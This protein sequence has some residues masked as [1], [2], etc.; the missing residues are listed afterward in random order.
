MVQPVL[1][2]GWTVT[3]TLENVPN[4]NYGQTIYGNTFFTRWTYLAT[5]ENGQLVAAS[6][7]ESDAYNQARAIA[8]QR[9]QRAPYNEAI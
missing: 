7:D 5:D 8:E 9:T 2:P 3:R 1:P 4:P 6:G